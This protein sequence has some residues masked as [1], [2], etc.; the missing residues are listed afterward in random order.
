MKEI[1]KDKIVIAI[2]IIVA[3]NVLYPI[4]TRIYVALDKL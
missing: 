2:I 3:L 4:L 1:I